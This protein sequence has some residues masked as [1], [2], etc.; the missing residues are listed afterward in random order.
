MRLY[1][2]NPIKVYNTLSGEKESFIPLHDGNVGMY[3]CG[4]TVYNYVHLGNVRTFMSFDVI[5][6][7]L[8]HLGYNVRYVRN[9][10]DAG[11]LTDDGNVENDRF[12]KQSRLEKLEPMEVVQKYTVYFHKV[13]DLFNFLPPSIEPTATGHILEQI[14]L[15]QKLINKGLAYESQGSVYFDVEEYNK[16]GLNYGELSNRNID[17]LFANTRDLDGQNEKKNPQDFALWKFASPAHIMRW[18]SPWGEGFPGWHLECTAMSTKYLG[19][20]FDI[21]GGGMDL[22]FPHHECEIA[23][24]KGCNGSSP[25]KYWMHANMLT[26]NG[27]RMSKSTGNFILPMELISGNNTFF[28]KAFNPSIIRFCFLQAHYRSELDISNDA[29]IASEKG[30]NRLMEAIKN[31]DLITPK[32]QSSVDIPQWVENCYQAM[33]DDFNTPILIANL[34]EGARIIN[35]VKDGKETISKEDL[36]LIRKTMNNFV[37][38]ILGI[39]NQSSIN[40]NSSKLNGVIEMLITMRKDARINKNWALSDQIRDQLLELGIQLK[41]GKEGTTYTY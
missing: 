18:N 37:F 21:H 13:L 31:I 23:Q 17:E 16:Q 22:K 34:F 20:K 4:P 27:L 3:V 10:T 26:M 9:I 6:R 40:D 2:S 8:L 1:T 35:I 11:H 29:M 14:E 7:Y 36:D 28:E 24:G 38:D 33:N 41:D 30:Y 25:V 39:E 19:N 5:Y 32:N 15:I 12:V